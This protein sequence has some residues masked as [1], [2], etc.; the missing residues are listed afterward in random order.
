MRILVLTPTFL[1][2]V[3]GA[4]LVILQVY[5]RLA[6]RHSVLVLT[7][8]LNERILRHSA[9]NEYDSF[10]N[11][12]VERYA[13][14]VTFFKIPGH[15]LS[16][17]LLPPFSLTS[18]S[19]LARV[20][21]EFRPQVLNVHYVMPTGL[22]G[23]YA[24]KALG[25]PTVVTYNGRDVPGPGVPKMWK[26]WH[27]WVG[28]SCSG[29]T[30][31]SKYCRDVI[32]GR[33]SEVGHIVYNGVDQP[34]EADP[35]KARELRAVLNIAPGAPVLFALQR[36]DYLKRV[37]IIIES[38]RY[39]IEK[40]P[41]THL[42]IG[43]RGADLPRLKSCVERLKLENHVTFAGYIRSDE[44]PTYY[45][46]ADLFLF[47]STYETFGM[48][49][50]EAMSYGKAVVSVNDSAV[51]EV[52]D[53]GGT[54]T[55]VPKLEPDAFAGAVIQLLEKREMLEEFGRRGR[56][57]ALSVFSWDSIARQYEGVLDKS[58]GRAAATSP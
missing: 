38:L 2:A 52:V 23:V 57:K 49:L 7:P 17:G 19:R 25:V 39:V 43:G 13:D 56:D 1:P 48:V 58:S 42:V 30:F 5:R 20:V 36:L 22:A 12:R 32:Y 24:E 33:H 18:V 6:E 4:E 27:R 51:P 54:G 40:H 31:V 10:V 16:M 55:L 45:G 47:H 14:K 15:R 53:H 41:T 9:S 46:L 8:R 44:L 37:D 35:Q 3:G 50:A 26:Y 11:F 29:M 21:R 28:R 34:I